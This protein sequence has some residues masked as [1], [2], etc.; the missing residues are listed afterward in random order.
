MIGAGHVAA[1][2]HGARLTV[3][4]A[5]DV[6]RRVVW[7]AGICMS[8]LRVHASCCRIVMR[9]RSL[10]VR[11]AHMTFTGK[12]S[13][14]GNDVRLWCILFTAVLILGSA[15][16][17]MSRDYEMKAVGQVI[18]ASG[19]TVLE[20]FP[21]FREALSGLN[22]FSHVIVLYWFDR[23]D[24]PEKRATLKVHPR[25]DKRNPLTGVFATRSP[26]RPNPIAFSVCK[27][28]SVDGCTIAID[29]IDAFDGSPIIDLKPY[30][31]ISDCVSEAVVPAWVGSDPGKSKP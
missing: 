4:A 5:I 30:I 8:L 20:I 21:Q 19:R 31:P 1:D 17:S 14:V 6:A 12:D 10:S 28:R 13:S 15:G 29:G 25:A 2:P 22:G 24:T 18:K 11:V 27:I 9:D 3:A 26:R 23:N 7:H 16:K